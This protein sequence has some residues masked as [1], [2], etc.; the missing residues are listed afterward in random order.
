MRDRR[1]LLLS[2]PDDLTSG[3]GAKGSRRMAPRAPLIEDPKTAGRTSHEAQ[4]RVDRRIK[5]IMS[6]R[7]ASLR[8]A[9]LAAQRL[10]RP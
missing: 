1:E 4:M 5:D 10:S 3:W 9:Q 6:R 2:P 7:E 8:A